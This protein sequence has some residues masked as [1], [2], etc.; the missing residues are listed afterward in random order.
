M[1]LFG[2]SLEADVEPL[3][4]DQPSFVFRGMKVGVTKLPDAE[5]KG[6]IRNC[7]SQD[8]RTDICL[9]TKQGFGSFGEQPLNIQFV[10][11]IFVGFATNI[12]AYESDK[13][14][15]QLEA[16]YGNGCSTSY[17]GTSFSSDWCF[18]EG[19]LNVTLLKSGDFSLRFM[20]N[21][22]NPGGSPPVTN[23]EEL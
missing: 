23:A 9:S 7:E 13:M 1:A 6:T 12:N 19:N 15:D 11:D 20:P 22:I 8:R 14:F 5:A 17:G 16:V 2:E 4:K 21:D 3:R 18:K 10:N